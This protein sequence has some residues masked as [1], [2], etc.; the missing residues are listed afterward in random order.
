MFENERAV[1]A[2]MLGLA[3]R[4]MADVA[5]DE[6]DKQPFQGAN[7]PRWILTHLAICTDYAA[8]ALGGTLSLPKDW[9]KAYGPGSTPGN[10]DAPKP[11]KDELMQALAAGHARVAELTKTVD[12]DSLNKPHGLAILDGT[13]IVNVGQFVGHLMTSH[14]AGHLGQLS[15]WRRATG[16][17]PLF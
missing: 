3:Q 13:P 6:M 12:P 9:H 7:T 11:T 8:R 14:T 1:Y 16:R 17:P 2:F 4:Q 10:A 15:F 5:E